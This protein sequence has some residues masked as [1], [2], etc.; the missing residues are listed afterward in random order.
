MGF[1]PLYRILI[2]Y[3]CFLNL[4][5]FRWRWC[6]LRSQKK[7]DGMSACTD[8]EN[9]LSK[10]L[11]KKEFVSIDSFMS[12][13]TQ[14]CSEK[15]R[16]CLL[17]PNPHLMNLHCFVILTKFSDFITISHTVCFCLCKVAVSNLFLICVDVFVHFSILNFH[18]PLYTFSCHFHVVF[19]CDV[20][21]LYCT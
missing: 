19:K 15:M 14:P 9:N 20:I 8:H 1:K 3:G 21:I 12:Y 7:S 13:K 17:W 4:H 6:R 16:M 10:H 18:V 2:L 11:F 5:S